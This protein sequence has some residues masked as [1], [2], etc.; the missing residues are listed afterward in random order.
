[1][2]LNSIKMLKKLPDHFYPS[3]SRIPFLYYLFFVYRSNNVSFSQNII[4][5]LFKRNNRWFRRSFTQLC[6]TLMI[7]FCSNVGNMRVRSNVEL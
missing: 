5:E 6:L 4:F 7:I 1:M 3:M 2:E